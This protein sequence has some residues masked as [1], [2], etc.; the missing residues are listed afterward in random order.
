[1]LSLVDN[2]TSSAGELAG[3]ASTNPNGS[4]AAAQK[5]APSNVG[6]RVTL[7]CRGEASR[8]YGMTLTG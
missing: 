7:R 6:D 8:R 4:R 2:V 1:M 3:E 5:E